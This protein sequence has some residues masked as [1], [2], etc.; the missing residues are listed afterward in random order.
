MKNKEYIY[1]NKL[2][3]ILQ[4]NIIIQIQNYKGI[5]IQKY[6]C[7]KILSILFFNILEKQPKNTL[8]TKGII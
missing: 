2:R 7:P 6:K 4:T 8:M 5:P 3:F 1:Q